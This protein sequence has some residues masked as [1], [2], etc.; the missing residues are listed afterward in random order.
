MILLQETDFLYHF[1]ARL[2]PWVHYVPLAYNAADLLEKVLWLK[3]HPQ[4]ARRL[5]TNGKNFGASFLRLEDYHCYWASALEAVAGVATPDALVP[6]KASKVKLAPHH[7][8][9]LN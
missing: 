2:K 1:S 7:D 9:L 3:S 5:A 8:K 6:F 4:F